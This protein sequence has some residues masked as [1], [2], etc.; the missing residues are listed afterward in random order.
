MNRVYRVPNPDASN[1]QPPK[2]LDRLRQALRTKH[3]AYRNKQAYVGW[4]RR[5]ILSLEHPHI[6]VEIHSV[7]LFRRFAERISTLCREFPNS[8]SAESRPS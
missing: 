4:V 1:P 5:F 8:N 3:S 7:N 2:R 6:I